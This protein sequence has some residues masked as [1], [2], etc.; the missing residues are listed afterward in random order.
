MLAYEAIFAAS[1]ASR[2]QPITIEQT[3]IWETN[4]QS[5]TI[6]HFWKLQI[7]RCVRVVLKVL[8]NDD[9]YMDDESK[10]A[11]QSI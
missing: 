11:K 9:R 4:A 2:V 5:S 3:C 8:E 1:R 6:D 7:N 10:D